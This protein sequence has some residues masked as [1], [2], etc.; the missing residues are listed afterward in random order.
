MTGS[1]TPVPGRARDAGPTMHRWRG[2][3]GGMRRWTA[4]L[5]VCT[6]AAL[7][8]GAAVLGALGAPRRTPPIPSV[9]PGEAPVALPSLPGPIGSRGGPFLSDRTGRV[10][11]LHGVNVVEK[12][13]PYEVY[14]DR[15]KPWNFDTADARRIARLG[16]DVVRLGIIWEGLEPG[17]AK[18]NSPSTCRPGSPGNPHQLRLSVLVRYLGHIRQTVALLARFHIFTI[19]D[20]HQDVYS[21]VLG[22]E[23]APS[24]A[25]CTDGVRPTRPPGRWSRIYGTEAADIAYDHFWFNNVVGDLQ[26]QYDLVWS[27]VARSFRNDPWVIGFDPFNEP[28]STAAIGDN[29]RKFDGT[30]ECFYTGR[31][32]AAV[33]RTPKGV[34]GVRCP[35]DDPRTGLLPDLRRADPRALIFVEPAL[36]ASKGTATMLGP[37]P[38]RHLVFNVHVY[39]PDRSPVT[40]NPYNVATCSTEESRAFRRRLI[41]R[42]G[43][44]S[45]QQPDGPAMIVTEFGATSDPA[46]LRNT[47]AGFDRSLMSWIYWAWKYYRDPTGSSDEALVKVTGRLRPTASVLSQVY[48]EAIAGTPQS[49]SFDPTTARFLLRYRTRRR[50]TTPTLIVV[51][52]TVHYRRGYCARVIGGTVLSPL[53]SSLLEVSGGDVGR[54]HEVTVRVSPGRCGPPR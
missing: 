52:T 11:L 8:A 30:L 33:V 12:R 35:P 32:H 22:G 2:S 21:S 42:L 31:A 3:A 43:M 7:V 28:F 20:M 27:L 26:G 41:E 9:R 39:C 44:A 53:D 38:F 18:S 10:V 46:V 54:A 40:G 45:R 19:L 5:L 37:M 49:M 36:Y 15:G 29:G 17:T 34:A 23:G 6:L 13:P 51:P 1:A 16:F 24:W 50:V 47:T 4:W 25:V 48:A 14:P